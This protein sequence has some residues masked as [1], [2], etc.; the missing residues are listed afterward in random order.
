[1]IAVRK[2]W[3][4]FAEFVTITLAIVFVVTLVRPDWSPWRKSIVEIRESAL[5]GGLLPAGQAQRALTYSEAAKKAMPSVVNIS[6]NKKIRPPAN[7]PLLKDPLLR[8]FYGLPE[9]DQPQSSLGSGVIV[10]AQGYILTNEHVV[11]AS[12]DIQIALSDGRVFSAKVV[13]AD[14]DTDLAVLKIDASDIKP[15]TFGQSDRAQVGDVV[16]A[17]GDPF[18]IGNTVT[19]GIVSALGRSRLGVNTYENFIQTD[20][21]INPGNSGGALVD[22]NGNLI[23]INSVIYSQSGGSQGIGFAIPVSMAKN[24]MEQIIANGSVTRGWIGIEVNDVTPDLAESLSLKTA[25]GALVTG[26]VRASPAERGGMQPGDV[27]VQIDGKPAIDSVA[28]RG[29]I[30]ELAPGKGTAFTVI[31]KQKE[32]NLQVAVGKRPRINAR[33]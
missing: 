7:H 22:I 26:V 30:S 14:P 12:N 5:P 20:A 32:V 4:L 15:V 25:R 3:L 27:I 16:L 23:G 33:Q 21:A 9:E 8:R 6:S 24:V 29:M 10:S 1:M 28:A 18:G 13:G 17:I 11:E 19:M 2:L 31:R